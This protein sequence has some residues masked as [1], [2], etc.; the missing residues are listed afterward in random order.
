MSQPLPPLWRELLDEIA[1]RGPLVR[2]TAEWLCL[3]WPVEQP[4]Q[5][6]QVS[7]L[8]AHGRMCVVLTADVCPAD[9]ASARDALELAAKVLVG[10]LVIQRGVLALRHVFVEGRFTRDQLYETL[11]TL[12]DNAIRYR[13]QLLPAKDV[14]TLGLFKYVSE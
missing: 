11:E 1:A 5:T 6:V 12:R 9:I 4:R 13:D 8:W 2:R 10:G 14:S 7:T 3:G